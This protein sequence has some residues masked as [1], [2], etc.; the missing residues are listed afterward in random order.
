V[1]GLGAAASDVR[2][3]AVAGIGVGGGSVTGVAAAGGYTR[4]E[5][6]VLRGLSVA[7][8]NDVRGQQRGLTIGLYNYA[9]VLH[10]LQLGL[11]NVARNNPRGLQVLPI[12]NANL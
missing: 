12:V 7:A 9:R 1:A 4:V 11:V 6:G 5:N 10:G 3:L 8:Y 2:G